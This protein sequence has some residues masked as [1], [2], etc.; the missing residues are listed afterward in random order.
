MLF[1]TPRVNESTGFSREIVLPDLEREVPSKFATTEDGSN[2]LLEEDELVVKEVSGKENFVGVE[3]R[4]VPG[5]GLGLV[6]VTNFPRGSVILKERSVLTVPIVPVGGDNKGILW[7]RQMVDM[8]SQYSK[9]SSV[10]IDQLEG[11]RRE[12]DE[13][14]SSLVRGVLR[15]NCIRVDDTHCGVYLTISRINHSCW[16]N[17][18]EDGGELK[19]VRATRDINAGEEITMSYI[20]N[21]WE[22]W[23]VRARELAYWNFVCSCEVC[24]LRGGMRER[25]ETLREVVKVKEKALEDFIL[26][27]D[28]VEDKKNP[29]SKDD[30]RL[31]NIEIY[32]GLEKMIKTAEEAMSLVSSARHQTIEQVFRLYL[33]CYLLYCKARVL[34]KLGADR[35]TCRILQL[36]SRAQ[37]LAGGAENF[38][39]QLARAVGRSMFY[40]V[41][42][43]YA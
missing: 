28:T 14:T 42:T 19:E 21:N 33:S 38:R 13:E 11:L 1:D 30:R 31:L 22:L 24:G 5:K 7:F 10:E 34:G 20:S 26:K 8:I 40:H 3:V 41:T 35:V 27:M 12:K 2:P 16:P 32:F 29:L 36:A 6:A 18:M 15:S 4:Q 37:I 39:Q 9:L 17:S 25:E 43:T 23:E